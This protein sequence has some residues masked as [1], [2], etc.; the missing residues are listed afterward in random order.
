[1]AYRASNAQSA[2]ASTSAGAKG[3]VDKFKV[4]GNGG[5]GTSSGGEFTLANKRILLYC[6][7]GIRCEKASA[8]VRSLVPNHK[9]VYHLQGVIPKYVERYGVEGHFLGNLFVFHRRNAVDPADAKK[10]A[11]AL[12]T[13]RTK[14]DDGGGNVE[15][16]EHAKDPFDRSNGGVEES[17][18]GW[19]EDGKVAG[20]AAAA[21]ASTTIV[22]GR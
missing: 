22:V 7:G 9:G 11:I 15:G 12:M 5:D 6:T 13:T 3:D 17:N 16:D 8:C 20:V 21:A 1:M 18:N 14:A 10:D 19:D 2:A 4:E